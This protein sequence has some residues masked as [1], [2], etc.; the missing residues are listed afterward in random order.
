LAFR[1]RLAGVEHHRDPSSRQRPDDI[2]NAFEPVI[3]MIEQR[4]V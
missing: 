1:Y 4:T 2:G 3:A